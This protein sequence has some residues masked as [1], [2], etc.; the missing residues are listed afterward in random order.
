M[1]MAEF[2]FSP[3]TVCS[4]ITVEVFFFCILLEIKLNAF[5]KLTIASYSLLMMFIRNEPYL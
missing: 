2:V 5:S 3:K 1:I 4:F